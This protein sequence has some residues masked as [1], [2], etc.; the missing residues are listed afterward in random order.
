[1]HVIVSWALPIHCLALFGL[2]GLAVSA[3]AENAQP[4]TVSWVSAEEHFREMDKDHNGLVTVSEM[5]AYLEA[6]HGKDY[7]KAILDKMQTVERGASC[8]TAFAQPFY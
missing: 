3:V 4:D 2:S 5:R 6:K 1:M 7:E 8:S